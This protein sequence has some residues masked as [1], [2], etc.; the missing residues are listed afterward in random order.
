MSR[1][2]KRLPTS[3]T[4]TSS[5]GRQ[6]RRNLRPRVRPAV[7]TLEDRI[8]PTGSPLYPD[9]IG[10]AD[11]GSG[12]LYGWSIDTT[13]QPGHTLLRL[14]S[15]EANA[16][17][18]P[19][20]LHGGATDPTTGTQEVWQWIYN[21]DGTHSEHLA[22]HFVWHPS[23]G[24]FHF[25]NIAAYRLRAVNADGSIGAILATGG[26]T[27]FCLI[28]I[29]HFSGRTYTDSTGT[30]TYP[31]FPGSPASGVYNSLSLIHI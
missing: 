30:H 12:Y 19:L 10:L 29:D 25:D 16:G 8:V 9:L 13:S 4:N 22:G 21:T 11:Q 7:E 1:L 24:H 15:T 23:H 2:S 20:E 6:G 17:A 3:N 31:T 14:T 27:S 5:T 18:G 26:K 28:D